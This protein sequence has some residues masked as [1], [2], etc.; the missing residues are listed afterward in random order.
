MVCFWL[1]VRP[2]LRRLQGIDDGFWRDALTGTLEAP[3][4]GG[5]KRDR[6]LPARLTTREGELRV[7]PVAPRGSHDLAAFARGTGLVRIRAGSAAADAGSR[8]R[9]LPVGA[10]HQLA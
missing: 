1:F 2:A 6:F 4:P 7:T 10:G 3:L 8:C 9:V 5:G